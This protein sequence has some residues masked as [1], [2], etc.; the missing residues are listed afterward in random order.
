MHIKCVL[1]SSNSIV[2]V[3]DLNSFYMLAGKLNSTCIETMLFFNL[4]DNRDNYYNKFFENKDYLDMHLIKN[5][6][7]SKSCSV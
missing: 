5:I 2:M 4:I 3:N 7:G 6:D 1:Q